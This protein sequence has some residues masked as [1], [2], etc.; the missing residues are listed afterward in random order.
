M[1]YNVGMLAL[2][3]I[4]ILVLVIVV[5]LA[6]IFWSMSVYYRE[7]NKNLKERNAYL[8]NYIRYYGGNN[9]NYL[10]VKQR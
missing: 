8:E 9:S 10:E 1:D 4:F 3:L 6:I 5:P 7:V 2:F